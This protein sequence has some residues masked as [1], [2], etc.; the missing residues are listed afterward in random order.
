V[1]GKGNR[2]Q[3]LRTTVRGR[4]PKDAGLQAGC[5]TEIA[6]G[7]RGRGKE[8]AMSVARIVRLA[9][10][11]LAAAGLFVPDSE[12]ATKSGRGNIQA[13]DWNVMQMAIKGVDGKVNTF[14]VRRDTSVKFSAEGGE[15]FPHPT[16]R[17]LA[18]PMYIWFNY[19]DFNGQEAPTIQDIDV[20]EIP[21]GA[22]RN[23]RSE[24]TNNPGSRVGQSR[25]MTVRIMKITNE[26]R[27]EFRAD[28]A[29]RQQDFRVVQPNMLSRWNEGD[30][31]IITVEGRNT[32]TDIRRAEGRDRR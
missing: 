10:I 14:R 20:R 19:E 31:V 13:V 26:R 2:P 17:D 4:I 1:G 8:F 15:N 11:S 5:Y 12:A 18:P 30:L 21:R 29:G 32:V 28:V 22:G 16:L 25:D 23:P 9:A 3:I 27:G 6:R 7:L 24:P